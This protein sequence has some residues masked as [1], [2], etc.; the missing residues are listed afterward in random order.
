[1][2]SITYMYLYTYVYIYIVLQ[3][4]NKETLLHVCNNATSFISSQHVQ[5]YRQTWLHLASLSFVVGGN[6]IGQFTAFN[7]SQ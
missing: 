4:I 5:L 7:L 3:D 1:M 2:N 6:G